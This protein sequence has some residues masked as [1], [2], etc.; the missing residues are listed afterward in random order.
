MAVTSL[1]IQPTLDNN[2]ALVLVQDTTDYAGQGVPL[3]GS[4]TIAGYV[5][6]E[7]T[8]ATGTAVLYNNI[9]GSS[10][11]INPNV[12][13]TNS[14]TIPLAQDTNGNIA[15]GTYTFTYYVTITYGV[16]DYDVTLTQTYDYDMTLPVVCLTASINCASS[17]IMSF[18]ET[19]YGAYVTSLSRTHNLYPPAALNLPVITGT[20]AALQAGPNIYDDTWS[21][22]LDTFATYTF[23]DGLIV[24]LRIQG[25]RE[26][27]VTC[28][29]GLG[30]IYCCLEKLQKRYERELTRNPSNAATTYQDTMKPTQ[31]AMLFYK[32]ALDCGNSNGA[33]YWYDQI[34]QRSG[35]GEDCGCSSDGPQQIYP[36]T[37]TVGQF[38]VD[39]PD[40]SI[41]V[42]P[43]TVGNVTTFHVQVSSAIQTLISNMFNT[44]VTT[45][46]PSD[47][48]IVQTGSIPNRNYEIN[49]IGSSSSAINICSKQFM[50]DPTTA[51]SSPYLGFTQSDILNVGS[52]I[53]VVG[54][55]TVVLGTTSPNA[56]TDPAVFLIDSILVDP[57]APASITAEVMRTN[58]SV[59]YTNIANL[60]AEVFHRDYTTG[61]IIV[62]LYNPLT[63]QPY[64][65]GDIT[66]GTFDKIYISFNVIA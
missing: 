52:A 6:V 56:S 34:I 30:R 17:I 43:E 27:K 40:N 25:S 21:Q 24:V 48:Q 45:G 20:V 54:S 2:Q 63:G 3:D 55:Q 36:L 60:K 37:A 59:S 13:D 1:S 39:S 10:P 38:L 11:D 29:I 22:S 4:Y 19:V 47:I 26:F 9:G 5:K 18:D 15:P 51:A 64:T 33:A 61:R 46:T 66:S 65:L 14:T 28:D 50:I 32:S 7:L 41:S 35:C 44:T 42:V 8:S 31:E 12:S 16:V 49:Y 23:P 53:N 58:D 62:R 57:T